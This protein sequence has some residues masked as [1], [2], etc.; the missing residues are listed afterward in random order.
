MCLFPST[1]L[2]FCALDSVFGFCAT[3]PDEPHAVSLAR[4]PEA[5]LSPGVSG[6]QSR[7]EEEGGWR[8]EFG[9]IGVEQGKESTVMLEDL[10]VCW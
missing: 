8:V 7:F 5:F 6:A 10:A 3:V 4:L 9:K 2:G 1:C